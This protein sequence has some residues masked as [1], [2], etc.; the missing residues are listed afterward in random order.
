MTDEKNNTNKPKNQFELDPER[1]ATTDEEGHRVYLYPE[2]VKG[3]WK[4]RRHLF[5]W[6]LT[7][8]YLVVPWIYIKNKPML[9]ID[10]FHREFTLMGNTWFGIEPI[11]LF[12][13]IIS[14]LFFVAFMTS[15]YG[16]VWCGW[17]CPQTVFIQGLFLKIDKLVEGS[18]RKRRELDQGP[19]T[20]E[21][22]ARKTVKWTIYLIISL[23]IA[24]TFAGY[25]LGPRELLQMSLHS[26]ME[27]RGIF[28]AVM[29]F[30]GILLLDFGWFREQFCII[31][32]PYG[33]MQ[34][35]MMD[36]NSLVVAYDSKRGEPRRGDVSKD[37]EGDCINCYHC[38]KVCPTGIDIR[39]GTQLECIACT[40]CIDACDEVMEKLHK[41]KGLIRYS[42]ENE[43]MGKIRKAI[44][45]RSII[46][47]VI[48]FSFIITLVTFLSQSGNLNFQF[49]RGIEAPFQVV[50]NADGSSLVINHFTMKVTHQ[51]STE[52]I[53]KL[54]VQD[55]A[56]RDKVQIVTILNP[57]K[58]DKPEMKTPIF[59]K[60]SPKILSEGKRML[61]V[62]VKENDI[63]TN[64]VEVPLAGPIINN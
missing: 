40:N 24:H 25:I 33:R 28:I 23:H 39:R 62:N 56:L 52:H 32:C 27:N 59:L 14:T 53:V 31:A 41:P 5:Y 58:F 57:L 4:D 6:F 43:L 50:K 61:K 46:Y 44:T 2:D 9:Q 34:S 11:F 37:K 55:L 22:I 21:K 12:L 48:S 54:E 29:I 1:L 20:F 16:R 7:F 64:T 30:T 15:L 42:S 36:E 19:L 63:L 47:I 10:I 45:P 49:Y 38:V 8:V 17:A 3:K 35:V 13:V 60:F 26:P 18:A 51:G